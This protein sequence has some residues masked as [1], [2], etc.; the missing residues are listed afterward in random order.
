MR[1]G[2]HDL[3]DSVFTMDANWCSRCV[4]ICNLTELSFSEKNFHLLQSEL[5]QVLEVL[6][7]ANKKIAWFEE[8]FKLSRDRQF[9]RSSEKLP[10]QQILFD[11]MECDE[12]KTVEE[13]ETITYT[14]SKP[15]KSCGRKLD[16]SKLPRERVLHDVEEKICGCGKALV[17]IGEDTSEQVE[18]IPAVLKVIEHVTPKYACHT[19]KKIVQGKKPET[20]VPK[21]MAANSLIA[22][23]VVKK[24]QY[25][26]PLY[27]Q[28]KLFK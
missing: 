15:K 7:Q 26:L 9:G 21:A 3:C 8:Q 16:T 5:Q 2:V 22:D 19:C 6:D 10:S 28:S 20:V 4:R 13:K 18:L 23:V 24:Y 27:R 17:K 12:I 1:I 25:H 11:A 14:R